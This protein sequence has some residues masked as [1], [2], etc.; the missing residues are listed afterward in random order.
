MSAGS[1]DFL[2][3]FAILSFEFFNEVRVEW[4][5]T[6]RSGKTH[7]SVG[8]FIPCI[9]S[10]LYATVECPIMGL[11]NTTIRRF[12]WTSVYHAVHIYSLLLS[13]CAMGSVASSFSFRIVI[14]A[15]KFSGLRSYFVRSF[16]AAV[17]SE[18]VPCFLPNSESN[19]LIL[20][21]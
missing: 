7:A 12:F 13:T 8:E 20:S 10:F 16:T 14:M 18:S 4:A 11:A 2:G 6:R 9:F 15:G 1:S 5:Y 21:R 19:S 3:F 17:A